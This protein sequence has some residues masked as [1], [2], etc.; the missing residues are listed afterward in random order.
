[1]NGDPMIIELR[2]IL[3][4]KLVTYMASETRTSTISEWCDG[5][6][7][8]TE[9]VRLRLHIAHC[10]AKIM[11]RRDS[12][13]TT[14]TWFQGMNPILGD[15]APARAIREWPLTPRLGH[16]IIQAARETL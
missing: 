5:S 6:A 8:P 1:M 11:T 3:G 9:T 12:K 13:T 10:A 4:A 14:Q 15:E 16:E 7:Y 2:D